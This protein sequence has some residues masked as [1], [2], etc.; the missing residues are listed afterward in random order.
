MQALLFGFRGRFNRARFWFVH[1]GVAAATIILASIAFISSVLSAGA[2]GARATAGVAG[3]VVVLLLVPLTW[4]GLAASVKRWHDCGK[5]GWWMLVT[6]V[7]V[8]G[9]LWFLIECGFLPG[10]PG[11]NSYGPDPLD[12]N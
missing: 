10:T 1:V 12:G 3:I 2:E 5:S 6:L 8:I 4:I 11:P 7:P 9:G